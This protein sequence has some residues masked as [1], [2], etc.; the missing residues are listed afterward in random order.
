MI[1]L[2]NNF[3]TLDLKSSYETGQDDLIEEFYAPVLK[4]AASYN[5]IA[6]FFFVHKP[7]SCG[8]GNCRADTK[9]WK[10]EAD[11]LPAFG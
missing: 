6:G 10:D 1:F 9:P 4:C 7:C 2:G 11:F 8:K 5:R 3:K